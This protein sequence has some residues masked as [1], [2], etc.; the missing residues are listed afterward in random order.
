MDDICPFHG[1]F[2]VTSTNNAHTF[3]QE[4]TTALFELEL[5]NECPSKPFVTTAP[6]SC[7]DRTGSLTISLNAFIWPLFVM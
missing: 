4:L 7:I 5:G 2:R 3:C 1:T 6:Q